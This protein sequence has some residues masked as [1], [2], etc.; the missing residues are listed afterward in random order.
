MLEQDRAR[1][2]ITYHHTFCVIMTIIHFIRSLSPNCMIWRYNG[3]TTPVRFFTVCS[4]LHLTVTWRSRC[5]EITKS[6]KNLLISLCFLSLLHI[7]P[8]KLYLTLEIF[9]V[10]FIHTL[11][12]YVL[13]IFIY[14]NKQY[15]AEAAFSNWLTSNKAK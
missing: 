6:A 15:L 5:E 12:E 10:P 13:H 9:F 7:S 2:D 8:Y 3:V 14:T 1:L 11:A 4:F